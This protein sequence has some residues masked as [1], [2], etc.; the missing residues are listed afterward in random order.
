MTVYNEVHDMMMNNL[1]LEVLDSLHG[2]IYL[3][4]ASIHLYRTCHE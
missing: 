4:Q 3:K 2:W 1:N